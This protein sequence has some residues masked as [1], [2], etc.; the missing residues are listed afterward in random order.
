MFRA[1]AWGSA[2]PA[3]IALA[4]CA[5]GGSGS[6]KGALDA[7]AESYV[8]LVLAVGRHDPNYVDAFYGP[9]AWKAEAEAAEPVAL[10]E[11]ARGARDLLATVRAAKGPA[12]RKRYLEK[13]LVAV[14]AE[15]R[16]L[17]GERFTLDD[18]CEALFDARPPRHDVAE[19]Q[20]AHDA[21]EK[22]VPGTGPL[23]DRIEAMRRAIRVPREHVEATVRAALATARASGA[24]QAGLPPG[25]SF[26]F[27]LVTGKPW[28]AYNWYLGN[29]RSRIEFNVDLPT[30]LNGLLGTMCHEGYPGHHT[31]NVLVEEHL[32]KGR[33]WVEWSVYPLYSP[34]SLIAEGTANAAEDLIFSDDERRRVLASVLAPVGHVDPQAVLAWDAVQE[35]MLPLRHVRPEAARMLLDDGTPDEE[36]VA[37]VKRWSL[38][39]DARAKKALDFARVYRS[40]VFNYTLGED[41]VRAYIGD[42][43]DRIE[44]FYGLLSRPVVPS[45]LK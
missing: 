18:E 13:Q 3:M 27:V 20:A 2:V 22:L 33:G 21:L 30:E 11:L 44:K 14:Y 7:A 35:A 5:S 9:P 39:D 26:E 23:A 15:V 31:Y 40:Y 37:F 45:D 4:A 32:V 25:E 17:S 12:D 28:G 42:G 16:R 1:V 34:Q 6:A 41:L 10:P 43:P 24:P 8:K 19:F 36:V 38:V 29:D